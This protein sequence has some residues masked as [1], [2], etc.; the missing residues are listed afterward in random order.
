MS[1][2]RR[3][4]SSSRAAGTSLASEG[5][6]LDASRNGIDQHCRSGRGG[7]LSRTSWVRLTSLAVLAE[8]SELSREIIAAAPPQGVRPSK[9]DRLPGQVA[10]GQDHRLLAAVVGLRCEVWGASVRF[11]RSSRCH[12]QRD[13]RC[14]P[15]CEQRRLSQGRLPSRASSGPATKCPKYVQ[16]HEKSSSADSRARTAD[17]VQTP[18]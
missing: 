1:R 6:T 11:R 12:R 4:G 8:G 7:E 9:D 3:P 16:T 14:T 17:G 18:M 10:V 13:R 15:T 2:I 5:C